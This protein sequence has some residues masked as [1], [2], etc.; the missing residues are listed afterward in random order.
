MVIAVLLL[1]VEIDQAP[2]FILQYQHGTYSRVEKYC[3]LT[4]SILA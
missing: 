4:K 2:S 3:T 1:D